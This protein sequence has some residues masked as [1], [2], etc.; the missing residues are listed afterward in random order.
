M[1]A[2]IRWLTKVE[3][4]RAAPPSGSGPRPYTTVVRFDGDA[5]PADDT[6]SLVVDKIESEGDYGWTAQVRFLV[7]EAPTEKLFSGQRFELYE[8]TKLVATGTLLDSRP[9]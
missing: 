5:W 1:L 4:G 2:K 9:F 8:G 3:G 6:W 7:P